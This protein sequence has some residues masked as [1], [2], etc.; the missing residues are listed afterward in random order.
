MALAD[1]GFPRGEYAKLLFDKFRVENCMKEIGR[2][3]GRVP[4]PPGSA[5]ES[6]N[7]TKLIVVIVAWWFLFFLWFCQIYYDEIS[8]NIMYSILLKRL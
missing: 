4:S 1:P 7:H 6:V 5:N 2:R 8:K 3:E